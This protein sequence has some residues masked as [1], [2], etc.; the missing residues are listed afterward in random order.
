MAGPGQGHRLVSST[1]ILQQ[2]PLGPAGK[3]R[4]QAVGSRQSFW[5]S[6]SVERRTGPLSSYLEL[7]VGH[8][9]RLLQEQLRSLRVTISGVSLLSSPPLP[10]SPALMTMPWAGH[11]WGRW[12]V[13]CLLFLRRCRACRGRCEMDPG[14]RSIGSLPARVSFRKSDTSWCG[15]SQEP[16]VGVT[17]CLKQPHEAGSCAWSSYCVENDPFDAVIS[18]KNIASVI[19]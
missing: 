5:F 1:Q 16:P 12:Q 15:D 19:L 17:H 14:S 18:R 10:P 8:C 3:P 11:G 4:I 9:P 13:L 6:V 2:R 7:R